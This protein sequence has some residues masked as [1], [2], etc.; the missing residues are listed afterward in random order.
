MTDEAEDTSVPQ[1]L[2]EPPEA[3]EVLLYIASG[4]GVELSDDARAALETLMQELQTRDVEGFRTGVSC[5]SY[6]SCLPYSCT[7]ETCHPQY[8]KRCL[9]DAGCKIAGF[10]I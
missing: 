9:V 5:P 3:G 6:D 1:W 4:D 10:G 8:R 2:L 7:L